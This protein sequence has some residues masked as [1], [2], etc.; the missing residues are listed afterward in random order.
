MIAAQSILEGV[1]VVSF[2]QALSGLGA[3]RVWE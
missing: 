1:P 2:D 3:E